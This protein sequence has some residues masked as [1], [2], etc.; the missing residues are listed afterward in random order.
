[1]YKYGRAHALFHAVRLGESFITEE[2]VQG[3]IARAFTRLITEALHQLNGDL[4]IRKNDMETFEHL[5][6][7]KFSITR[8]PTRF[9]DHLNEIKDLIL[10]HNFIPFPT[11]P[12]TL[13]TIERYPSEDGYEHSKCFSL[14]LK[15]VLIYPDIVKC[16]KQIGYHNICR[17]LNDIVIK[18]MFIMF[19]PM[20]RPEDWVCPT[21]EI[22]VNK[23]RQLINLGFE[24][25]DNLIKSIVELFEA[26][27][28]MIGEIIIKVFVLIRGQ[29]VMKVVT[30]VLTEKKYVL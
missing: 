25:T 6:T 5:T 26:R 13:P 23:L 7:C 14:I 21:P 9:N 28:D 10:N 12:R 20:A 24:L 27:F 18:G 30:T 8:I 19:F 22:I 17:D 1:M 15:S 11:R 4:G 2:V 3:L 29:D 16:W